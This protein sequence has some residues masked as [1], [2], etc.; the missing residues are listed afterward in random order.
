V[1]VR[2]PQ[3]ARRLAEA[4][5]GNYCWH[6]QCCAPRSRIAR[7]PAPKIPAPS[8]WHRHRTL[9]GALPVHARGVRPPHPD[10][11]WTPRWAAQWAAMAAAAYRIVS[12]GT[13]AG[14]R[15]ASS[16]QAPKACNAR[17][18]PAQLTA[19]APHRAYFTWRWR[20]QAPDP[21]DAGVWLR[22][23]EGGRGPLPPKSN[24][25]EQLQ[26]RGRPVAP[27]AGLRRTRDGSAEGALC[28]PQTEGE[29]RA[30]PFGICG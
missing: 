30:I 8:M 27:C 9:P 11:P 26:P 6:C 20:G 17:E 28:A 23:G 7:A 16:L 15:G 10:T 3:A 19:S 14:L 24:R 1:A 13:E 29:W 12:Q 21:R 5:R 2:W 18:S 25:P 4:D 22:A